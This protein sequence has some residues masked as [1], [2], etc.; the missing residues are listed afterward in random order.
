[1]LQN[2]RHSSRQASA[3]IYQ[4]WLSRQLGRGWLQTAWKAS[5]AIHIAGQKRCG[6]AS[7]PCLKCKKLVRLLHKLHWSTMLLEHSM[8]AQISKEIVIRWNHA[9]LRFPTPLVKTGAKDNLPDSCQGIFTLPLPPAI[10]CIKVLDRSREKWCYMDWAHAALGLAIY[11]FNFVQFAQGQAS[12]WFGTEDF[13]WWHRKRPWTA[14]HL[15]RA[16]HTVAPG[17]FLRWCASFRM[18]SLS[19]LLIFFTTSTTF[20][21]P[22]FTSS[23]EM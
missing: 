22:A 23:S 19:F 3:K 5:N 7:V 18:A 15:H 1:M 4:P 6:T 10:W 20:T 17:R 8:L 12:A 16:P 14:T 9:A 21:L 2:S 11:G 13:Q